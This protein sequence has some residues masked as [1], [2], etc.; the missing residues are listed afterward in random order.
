MN[1]PVLPKTQ[2]LLEIIVIFFTLAGTLLGV[3]SV[4]GELT[5]ELELYRQM[6]EEYA[7]ETTAELQ[8]LEQNCMNITSELN[9]E[10]MNRKADYLEIKVQLT[11]IQ[12][13]Q[14]WLITNWNKN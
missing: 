3:G 11:K 14:E 9:L 1:N 2:R 12:T 10:T 13:G 8:A 5:T 4:V 6:H 7:V